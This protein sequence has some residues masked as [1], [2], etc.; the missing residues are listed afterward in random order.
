MQMS[1]LSTEQNAM[2][3]QKQKLKKKKMLSKKI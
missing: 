1:R 3:D 2:S